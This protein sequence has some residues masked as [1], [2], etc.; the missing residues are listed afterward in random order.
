MT[1]C[2]KDSPFLTSHR[3]RSILLAVLLGFCAQTSFC[4]HQPYNSYLRG[5]PTYDEMVY[6]ESMRCVRVV[7]RRLNN[8]KTCEQQIMEPLKKG[9][10]VEALYGK[11][12]AV[13]LQWHEAT[14]NEDN[15]DGT[16]QVEYFH[17]YIRKV[18]A[19]RIRRKQCVKCGAMVGP[20][21]RDATNKSGSWRCPNCLHTDKAGSWYKIVRYGMPC[22]TSPLAPTKNL[23]RQVPPPKHNVMPSTLMTRRR[24][25]YLNV[26]TRRFLLQKKSDA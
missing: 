3:Q 23:P 16:Y 5:S 21:Q 9:D 4:A 20:G 24:N 12:R 1:K 22:R 11:K 7:R 18:K 19:N 6:D 2:L 8:M 26:T 15:G 17:N 10:T 13:G 25:S 14:I